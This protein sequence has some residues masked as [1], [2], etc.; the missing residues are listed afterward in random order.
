MTGK[1]NDGENTPKNED[2]EGKVLSLL[3]TLS[4]RISALESPPDDD[5]ETV[6]LTD[7]EKLAREIIIGQFDGLLPV[8]QLDALSLEVLAP[9]SKLKNVLI[10][11]LKESQGNVLNPPRDLK[12]ADV[13]KSI[14]DYKTNAFTCKVKP[15]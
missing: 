3:D 8:D 4:Q 14:S 1:N 10:E 11:N 12:D 7:S 6:E 9:L 5:E 13:G 15:T 2:F